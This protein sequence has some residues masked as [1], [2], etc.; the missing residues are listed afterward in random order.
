MIRFKVTEP[1]PVKMA[2]ADAVVVH[3]GGGEPYDGDYTIIPKAEVQT[4][5]PTQGKIMQRDVTVAKIPYY[6]TSN[7][8]GD[9][10]YIASEV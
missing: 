5:L 8:T 7:P 3:S 10:I 9:T 4:V 6:E 1:C 2:V